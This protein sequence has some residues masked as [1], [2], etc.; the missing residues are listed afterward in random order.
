MGVNN[1]DPKN[2]LIDD[3]KADWLA[4]SLTAASI[5]AGIFVYPHL[6][7]TVP[8][9]WN[10]HGQVDKYSSRTWG[11]FGLPLMTAGI[12]LIMVLAPRIDP[13]RENYARFRGA[14]RFLKLGLVVFF[15]WLYAVILANSLGY[16]MPV[17]RAVITALGILFMDI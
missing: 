11:A 7:E 3:I 14:Y 2:G 13:R 9:H 4:V 16:P 5:I 6:P 10:I 8:S 17:D 12:Y 15:I 1:R